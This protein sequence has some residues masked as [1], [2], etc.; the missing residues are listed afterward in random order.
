MGMSI[1]NMHFWG[2][3]VIFFLLRSWFG[4]RQLVVESVLDLQSSCVMAGTYPLFHLLRVRLVRPDPEGDRPHSRWQAVG[5]TA[6]G[7]LKGLSP[8]RGPT[9]GRSG[10]DGLRAARLD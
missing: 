8:I 6:A 4:H 2:D 3:P 10:G 9:P 5:L 1:E 7:S